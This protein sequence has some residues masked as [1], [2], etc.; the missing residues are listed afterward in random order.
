MAVLRT[1]DNASRKIA[2]R[3]II[4]QRERNGA[5]WLEIAASFGSDWDVSMTPR[6]VRA[7]FD[8]GKGAGSAAASSAGKGRPRTVTA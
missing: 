8:E 3:H 1:L 6:K 5:S 7:L 2:I 4:T